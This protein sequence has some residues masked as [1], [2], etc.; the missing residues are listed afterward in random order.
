MQRKNTL[1]KLLNALM[2]FGS[3]MTGNIGC[4][5]KQTRN[6][7]DRTFFLLASGLDAA[8]V[9]YKKLGPLLSEFFF[10][11]KSTC[12]QLQHLR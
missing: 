6:S 5:W 2:Q 8:D 12:T 4:V 11:N 10:P 7:L 1:G 3:L 9:K